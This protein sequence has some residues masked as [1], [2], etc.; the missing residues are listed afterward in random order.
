[1]KTIKTVIRR[2]TLSQR[3]VSSLLRGETLKLPCIDIINN[4]KYDL[5]IDA[6]IPSARDVANARLIAAAP[7]LLLAVKVALEFLD[8]QNH[9]RNI[10]EQIAFRE[11]QRGILRAAIAKAEG[12][13]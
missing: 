9:P 3:E 12:G 11:H 5:W 2:V 8:L 13:K 1:M 6:G 7:E 4:Q 10:E